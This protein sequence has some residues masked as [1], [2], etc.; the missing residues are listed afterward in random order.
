MFKTPNFYNKS[1]V[2]ELYLPRYKEVS[3]EAEQYRLQNKI[4]PAKQDQI[5]TALFV[6]DA[7]VG[8]CM[9]NAS[10]SVPGAIDDVDRICNFVYNNIDKITELHFSLD[11]H[12]V[13]QIF[14]AAF[15]VDKNGK[16]PEPLT[17][18]T[19]EDIKKGTWMPVV[20]VQYA[21]NY[22]KQL[23][24]TGKYTL[25]IWPYHTMLGSIDH[26][27][28]PALFECS[29]FHSIARSIQTKFET[30]GE[31]PLTENYS[32]LSPEVKNIGT[33]TNQLVVGQFN[34]KFFKTLMD[35]DR[36]YIAGEASS[37]CVKSTIEDLLLNIKNTDP[38]LVQKVY[39]LEDCMSPVPAI[40]NIVDF[41]AI[42]KAALDSFKQAGMNIV[43]S[44]DS[45]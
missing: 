39:I 20:H 15:W 22:V 12:R 17:M 11:T 43:K 45:I 3:T 27:L 16:H 2:G 18:I 13:F 9:P 35:N 19:Y 32:V 34:T 4:T 8:F 14:H 1:Q 29:I 31:H 25:I 30:K 6:I 10:L 5:K 37:H 42:A 44:T 24:E 7:Q 23:E 36:V 41:P 21:M 40:P 28:V 33:G 38:T 26:A